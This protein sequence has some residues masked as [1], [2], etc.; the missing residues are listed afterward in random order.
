VTD[1]NRFDVAK[2]NEYLLQ[3]GI[4]SQAYTQY[5]YFDAPITKDQFKKFKSHW[6]CSFHPD[7]NLEALLSINCGFNDTEVQ[8]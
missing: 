8:K 3:N 6:P 4:D 1:Y 7:S 2:A 5:V